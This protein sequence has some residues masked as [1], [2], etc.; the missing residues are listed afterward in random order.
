MFYTLLGKLTQA[1]PGALGENDRLRAK[2]LAVLLVAA[3]PMTGLQVATNVGPE[4]LKVVVWVVHLVLWL[5]YGLNR[6]RYFLLAPYLLVLLC[7]SLPFSAVV[8]GVEMVFFLH[9]QAISLLPAGLFLTPRRAFLVYLAN[10]ALLFGFFAASLSLLELRDQILFLSCVYV[11]VYL[12]A[13]VI[14]ED[15]RD[16][17]QKRAELAERAL[18]QAQTQTLLETSNRRLAVAQET[19][20]LAMLELDLE[21]LEV[22]WSEEFLFLLG[23]EDH[24]A[25]PSLQF[26]YD[27]IPEPARTQVQSAINDVVQEIRYAYILTHPIRTPSGR[28]NHVENKGRLV[29]GPG[30]KPTHLLLCL[31]E[32]TELVQVESQLRATIEDLERAN[33]TKTVLL[34][35]MSHELRT[36]LN[37]IIGMTQLALEGHLEEVQREMLNG[38][39]GA[40]RELLGILNAL[41]DLAQLESGHLKLQPKVMDLAE[42]LKPL[43]SVYE[44]L[45]KGKGLSFDCEIDPRLSVACIGDSGQIREIAAKLLENSLKF[46]SKGSFGLKVSCGGVEGDQLLLLLEVWDTGPGIDPERLEYLSSPFTQGEEG[47]TRRFGGLGLGLPLVVRLVRLMGGG[48]CLR[49]QLGQGSRFKVA[50]ALDLAEHQPA[51][52]WAPISKQPL[53]ILVVEDNP[54]SQ[55]LL[56]KMLGKVGVEVGLAKNGL[57]ALEKGST[58]SYDLV[59]MDLQMPVMDGFEATRQIRLGRAKDPK[60]PVVALT[61]NDSQEDRAKAQ[62]AGVDAFLAKPLEREQL[63]EVLRRFCPHK[64]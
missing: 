39:L 6:S 44:G 19:A 33:R 56:L 12:S 40:S 37:G 5:V 48:M 43:A 54:L 10:L 13:K 47:F 4:S 3:I 11:C 31:Y 63:F 62:S 41:L 29:F 14:L 52:V 38:S 18:Q 58:E 27:Q 16:L 2:I 53:R 23:L 15:R 46:T 21:T 60:V 20:H 26:F 28:V 34:A 22:F 64:L 25:P 30:G 50:L 45:A 8:A 17:R 35:N 7:L 51:P 24:H 32:V 9:W 36:P 49:S 57:E 42:E 55:K 61:A 59:L 1:P